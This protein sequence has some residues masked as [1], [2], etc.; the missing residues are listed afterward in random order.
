MSIDNE[1]TG[2]HGHRPADLL[3]AVLDGSVRDFALICRDGEHG[4]RVQVLTGEVGHHE[5]LD[6][7]DLGARGGAS[8]GAGADGSDVL[9]VVPYRQ[10]AERGYP[11]PDDGTPLIAMTV[12]QQEHHA[13]ASVLDRL[14]QH[15][16]RLANGRFE[17]DDAAYA[18]TVKSVIAD[19]IGTG[20]GANFVIKRTYL[21]DITGYR[22]E[23]AFSVFGEL[24]SRERGAYWTFLVQTRDATL[25]GASPERHV[26]L[27]D[28]V[29]TMNPISGTYRYPDGGPTLAGL[30]EFLADRKEAE[31][32][33]MVVDEELKMMCRVCE[34]GTVQVNGPHLKEMAKVAHTE[35]H[36]TGTS[37]ADIPEVLR[38]TMFA[39]TVTGSPVE[40]AARVIQRYEPEGRG[41]YSG[42]IGLAG[43][44]EQGRRTL[45]SAI[46][47]RTAVL[48]PTGKVA[49]SVGSTLVRHSDPQ[50]EV[51]ETRA[52]AKALLEAFGERAQGSSPAQDPRILDSLKSRN[53]GIAG[54]WVGQDA[55]RGVTSSL[56]EGRKA[57][58]IDAE[59]TFTS[60]LDHQLR[61]LGLSVT[62]RRFDETFEVRDHDVVLVGPGPGDPL[63]TE[64]PKIAA[65]DKV[66]GELLAERHPFVAVCLSHQVL[67]RRL[68][69]PLVRRERPNQGT[70]RQIDLFGSPERV[71]FYNTFE[72]R[73]ATANWTG[74]DGEQVEI[75]RN[76]DTDEVH[77][78][79]G[80]RFASLQFHAE[81]LLT[82][83]GPRILTDMFE[84]VL[85]P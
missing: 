49:I 52:K 16:V 54:F 66:V 72:A 64:H 1:P 33:Y 63:A 30:T 82:V 80:D 6:A 68:G 10:L 41:Y 38:A 28:G 14:P 8:A 81:S 57:L 23:Q 50:G 85:A 5:S 70:Q 43:T 75:S 61:A 25:I 73:S 44:D 46:L 58:V 26:S 60:M 67:S 65:L 9:V 39:P 56:L 71:G 78:L 76:P 83:D 15:A 21:A 18:Q 32:L 69:L 29:A 4:R 19:E 42:I 7:L 40:S 77:A 48:E 12:Q 17:P 20:E 62:V 2:A 37:G 55:G 13:V 84:G 27:A 3:Q 35:Y 53:D 47:I 45:D 11:A 22:P 34:P 51:A 31:E 59:D 24:L 36:I 74:P 79:R